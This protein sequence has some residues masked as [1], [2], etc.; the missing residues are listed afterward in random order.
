MCHHWIDRLSTVKPYRRCGK[1]C[2]TVRFKFFNN[3][4]NHAFVTHKFRVV[5]SPLSQQHVPIRRMAIAMQSRSILAN[6]FSVE[7]NLFLTLLCH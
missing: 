1:L 4:F 2:N 5:L 7:V 6:I 3:C